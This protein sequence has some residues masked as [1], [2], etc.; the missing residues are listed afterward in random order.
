MRAEVLRQH[1]LLRLRGFKTNSNSVTKVCDFIL[2]LVHGNRT[3][4]RVTKAEYQNREFYVLMDNNT[5]YSEEYSPKNLDQLKSD[6]HSIIEQYSQLAKQGNL[7]FV[8]F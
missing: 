5:K 4:L 3:I 2:D 1:K 7:S 8:N 6:Y